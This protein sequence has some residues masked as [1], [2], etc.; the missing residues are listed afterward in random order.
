MAGRYEKCLKCN[1]RA[2]GPIRSFVNLMM[3]FPRRWLARRVAANV[4]PSSHMKI[5]AALPRTRVIYHGVARASRSAVV[6]NPDSKQI[7]VFAFVGRLVKEKGGSVLL[8]AAQRL[9]QNGLE[10]RLRILGDGPAR[11]E[12]EALASQL[13]LQAQTEFMGTVPFADIGDA[14]ET[15]TAVVMPSTWEDVAPLVALELMMQGQLIIASDVGGLGETINGFGLKFPVGDIDAL[16]E[17]LRSA[18]ENPSRNAQIRIEAYS[19][20]RNTYTTERMVWEHLCL[21]E[22]LNKARSV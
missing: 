13:G 4:A 3:M 15:A 5:R 10:F 19:H 1:A 2:I 16:E 20:A 11:P 22:E 17:C 6:R 14:L 9:S 7:P 18:V 21:Y 8:R 12:L